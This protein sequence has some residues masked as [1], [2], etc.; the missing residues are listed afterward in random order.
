MKKLLGLL[1]LVSFVFQ[2]CQ[3]EEIGIRFKMDYN[4]SFTIEA[5]GGLNLPLDFF[6]P[7]VT[8]NS[9]AEF[10]ANDTRKDKIQEIKLESLSLA[11]TSPANQNFDFMKDIYLFINADGLDE[12]RYAFIENIPDGLTTITLNA[13]GV[14]LAEYIKKDKFSLRVEAVQDKTMTRDIDVSAAMV[15]DVKANP[16]K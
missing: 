5:G 9:E 11:I 8:T 15:F 4:T 2:G 10:E 12:Q 6:T 13:D 3:N 16:L 14:D 7:D 1:L